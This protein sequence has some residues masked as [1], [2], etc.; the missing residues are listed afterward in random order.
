MGR[1]LL[2]NY[3]NPIPLE[4]RYNTSCLGYPQNIPPEHM[5]WKIMIVPKGKLVVNNSNGLY[6]SFV[7]E[8]R[9]VKLLMDQ[10]AKSVSTI[11]KVFRWNAGS[12]SKT[13]STH[14]MFLRKIGHVP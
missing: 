5:G 7:P 9:F 8:E 3:T 12:M 1:N 13:M 11:H 6:R 4:R 10:E 2:P 14:N